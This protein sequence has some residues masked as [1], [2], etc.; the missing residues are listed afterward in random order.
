[1]TKR[2]EGLRGMWKRLINDGGKMFEWPSCGTKRLQRMGIWSIKWSPT[3]YLLFY[4]LQP[5]GIFFIHFGGSR[6]LQK[7]ADLPEMGRS[8]FTNYIMKK[9]NLHSQ[10]EINWFLL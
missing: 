6:C 9:L 4:W 1:L 7:V 10:F 3:Q 8:K 2:K 5:N